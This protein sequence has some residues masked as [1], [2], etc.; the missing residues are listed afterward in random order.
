MPHH[1]IQPLARALRH[2]L[3][4]G[5]MAT[6][7]MLPTLAYAAEAT[8]EV[9]TYAI[10][11]GSLDQALNRFASAS[12]ILLSVDATLTEGKRSAGLQG[13]YAVGAGLERLLAGSGLVAMQSQGGWSLQ[14]SASDGTLQLGATQISAQQAEESAWGPVDGIV[15]TRSASG[16]KTDSAL[17]EIP[18]TINVITAAEIKARGAQSV[19]QALLYTPGMSAGGFADRVKLFD[20]PT[21]RGFSPTPLYLDGLHLP[22]GGGSTGGALQIEPYSL[23]RIEVL[24][25]PASVLYGQN[26]PGGIVNMVSKRPSETPVHQVVLEAGTYEHK[27]AAIDLSGPLDEQGQFLYRL[28]GLANDGQ[29]EINYVENK[30]QFIAPSFTWRPNDDTHVTLF[31]QYQKDEGVPE[32]QGLPASGTL[33]A[34]PNGKIKRDVFIGEPGVNQYNREQYVLGYEIS[35]RLNETWTLKQNARY[36]EV[37][38]RYTAPLH[39]YRFVANPVTGVQDQRY[40]QRFGVDWA[41]NNKVFGVDSIAQAE[42]DTGALSHTLILG[43]DY[44]HSGS[45]FHGLY[46]RNPPI[47]DLFKPVYGQRL[48]FGQP[49]R[50]D[51][52]ITQ[53]GLYVQDQIKLDKWALV[54]GGRYDWANVVNKEPLT[55]TRF[56]SK[57]QAFTGRAGLVYLFDNGLA[58][59]VSYT[60]S[61]LP[62][63]GTDVNKK[64]FEPSTGN[65]Y[66][67][68][69]KY[70]PP[71]QKS[72][73]QVSVYQL[74]QENVLT[75]NPV[76]TTYS[77]QSGAM[78]S[79][80]VELEAKAALSD[81]WEIIASASR[82]DIKYTKDNDG[83]QGRHPAGIS[84][85]TASMWV[86]YT[87]LGD[88]PLAGLGA[89]LGVRYARQSLGDYYEGAFSVP[90]YSV[91][92]ASLSYDL[93]RSPLKLK[94]VKLALNVQNLTDKTYVSQCT[95]DLD[96][97][98]GQGRTAV[99]SLTYDW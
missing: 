9:R 48:N 85:L 87:V 67:V 38:D 54:L 50:W 83:R 95:S 32:A 52:T 57:D 17:V 77:T 5:L 31:A 55:D 81:A 59:F 71:G 96:C 68:G 98:Y 78:R 22:Y 14:A 23:E 72:F 20:E 12:G 90:S 80:G 1:P 21:S 92:D 34:N 7:P 2:G 18:Q 82:N 53:T 76:D 6:A 27:S 4:V 60:E 29:D 45:L 56:A 94:G 84:P 99:S 51:R 10:P 36:A 66:E 88:T 8:E 74:D 11:A 69:V 79:R 93:S 47:I 62:L 40:L 35:H 30:R 16:S 64:P 46:D 63:A 61:F 3:F 97:Y 49:Y 26:Q 24:K 44:Y 73:V 33:W 37:D 65:Q 75:T 86:N 19:T 15:A 70:Q 39:G 58:P 89:G 28:T 25:G 41:Q 13:R 43:L 42:F 91:Y